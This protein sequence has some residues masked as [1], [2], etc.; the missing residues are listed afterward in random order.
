MAKSLEDLQRDVRIALRN[1]N[2][3]QR[4]LRVSQEYGDPLEVERATRLVSLQLAAVA[5]TAKRAMAA[6]AALR[7]AGGT[8]PPESS[9]GSRKIASLCG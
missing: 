4:R 2:I 7:A 5:A 9:W 8:L 3:A 6:A 1:S